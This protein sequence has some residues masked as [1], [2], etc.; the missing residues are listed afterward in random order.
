MKMSNNTTGRPSA[1]SA[2]EHVASVV[3]LLALRRSSEGLAPSK[4]S[5]GRP[6]PLPH[7]GRNLPPR[8]GLS[9]LLSAP[10]ASK[11]TNF[12]SIQTN[13]SPMLQLTHNKRLHF[14]YS[15]QLNAFLAPPILQFTQNRPLHYQSLHFFYSIQMNGHHSP[16]TPHDTKSLRA[17][18]PLRPGLVAV[19]LRRD[20]RGVTWN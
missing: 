18:S 3:I 9:P 5:K 15:M 12:Y 1:L 7:P 8:A 11:T 20:F 14:F 13:R 2:S 6:A 17:V 4:F 16:I 10:P 19:M